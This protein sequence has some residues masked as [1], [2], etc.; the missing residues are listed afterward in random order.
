[1]VGQVVPVSGR[2]PAVFEDQVGAELTQVVHH[3]QVGP[4]AG[5]HRAAVV[6]PVV[7][8]RDER[9]MADGRGRGDAAGHQPPQ[10][11]IKVA[12]PAQVVGED[13]VGD[14]APRVAERA[15]GQQG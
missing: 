4:I 13:V 15:D 12:E 10:E 9:G 5:H 1:M 8:G 2:D 14:Q 6:E 11:P 3:D 7:A